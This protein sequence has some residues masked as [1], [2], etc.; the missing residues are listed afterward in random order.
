LASGIDKQPSKQGYVTQKT[1]PRGNYWEV[2]FKKINPVLSSWNLNQDEFRTETG[3]QNVEVT[4]DPAVRSLNLS[5]KDFRTCDFNHFTLDDSSF[6]DCTFDD[7]RFVKGDFTNVKFSNCRFNT[8]HFLYVSFKNC[9]FLDCTFSNISAS[10]ETVLFEDSTI[11]ASAFLKALV[12]NLDALPEHVTE[13]YQ[14]YRHFGTKAKIARAIFIS[15]R[16]EPEL[17]QMFDAN[18]CF[19]IALRQKRIEESRW[20]ELNGQITKRGFFYQLTVGGFRKAALWSIETAG[21]LTDW[22]RSPM[23]YV[24]W[25]A[26]WYSDTQNTLPRGN[27]DC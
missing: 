23:H 8:C 25:T 4:A 12:T 10:A 6:R 13:E 2:T 7:C 21:F 9:R 18:R 24:H 20:K 15:V 19:E 22:G 27:S 14:R 26:P 1:R 16:D 5:R 11:P 3:K 17:D